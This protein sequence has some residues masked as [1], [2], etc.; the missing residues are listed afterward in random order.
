[1]ALS[2]CRAAGPV[3]PVPF[4]GAAGTVRVLLPG[5]RVASVDLE[6]YVRSTVAAESWVPPGER[7]EVRARMLQIQAIVARTFAMASRG[8]HSDR[9][10]DVCATTHCQLFRE[11]REAGDRDDAIARAAQATRGRLLLFEGEPA[12]ALFHAACGGATTAA[13]EV[14]GGTPLPY[15]RGGD[16]AVCRR[17][18]VWETRLSLPTVVQVLDADPRTRVGGRLQ[19][20]IIE[21]TDASG[22]VSRVRLAGVHQ[23]VVRGEVLR[24]RLTA[25]FGPRAVRSTRFRVVLEGQTLVFRGTGFGHGAGLCQRGALARLRDGAQVEEVLAHYYPG[26][27]VGRAGST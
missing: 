19:A 12:L 27:R 6:S 22:R 23:P 14:W 11:S 25:G 5:G 24:A 17:S 16:D 10:A 15:L 8:R 2:A 21:A 13:D 1:M 9:N 20:I 4:P 3:Q 18:P 26:T 7:P